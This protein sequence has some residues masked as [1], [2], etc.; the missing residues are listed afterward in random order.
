MGDEE[1][2]DVNWVPHSHSHFYHGG[3][4]AIE[5]YTKALENR[6]RQ[7]PCSTMLGGE[8][9]QQVKENGFTIIPN[10]F[11]ESTIAQLKQE[12][13]EAVEKNHCKKDKYYTV[14]TDPLLC[15]PTILDVAT[16][17]IIFATVSEFFGC[18]PSIGTLNFRQSHVN[19]VL[20]IP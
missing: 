7:H 17:E 19:Q 6:R 20:Y 9:T 15:C 14:I 5:K 11:G 2:R 8:H 12:F 1:K 16:Q 13:D 10:A 3:M 18:V 4:P